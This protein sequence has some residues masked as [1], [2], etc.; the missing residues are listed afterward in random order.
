MKKKKI[1]HN[2]NMTKSEFPPGISWGFILDFSSLFLAILLLFS[3]FFFC[4]F[5]KLQPQGNQVSKF[6]H[7]SWSF[8]CYCYCQSGME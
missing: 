8:N 5:V 3:I 2:D 4:I 1:I 7:L 6:N